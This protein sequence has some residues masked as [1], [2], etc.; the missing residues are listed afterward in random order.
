VSTCSL[1]SLATF[2]CCVTDN[3][4][5]NLCTTF[6]SQRVIGK[7]RHKAPVQ[8]NACKIPVLTS[9][10]DMTFKL[11]LPSVLWRC[12]LGGRKGIWPVKNWVVGYWR[13]YLSG[14]RCKWFAYDPADAT[15]TPS[16]LAPV[17]SRMDYLSGA[18]LP[19][20]SWKKTVKWM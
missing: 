15:A 6:V 14:V 2:H 16:S 8:L 7:Q 4:A 9:W 12:W 17:K 3:Y 13:G 19:R 18:G 10:P 5:H 1:S 11:S 20:L